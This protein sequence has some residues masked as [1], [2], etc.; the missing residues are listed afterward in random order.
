[1]SNHMP[2][3]TPSTPSSIGQKSANAVFMVLKVCWL[4]VQELEQA[5]GEL[6]A[7]QNSASSREAELQAQ[8]TALK[9]EARTTQEE[10]AGLRGSLLEASEEAAALRLDKDRL[11]SRL[12]Q[13]S[14]VRDSRSLIICGLFCVQNFGMMPGWRQCCV[15]IWTKTL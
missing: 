13:Q 6:E 7:R 2:T 5:Q 3:P 14:R 15:S 10:A 4:L 11:D 8:V 9:Q 12:E 1:M